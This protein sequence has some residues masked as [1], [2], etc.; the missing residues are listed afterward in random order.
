[1]YITDPAGEFSPWS[2]KRGITEKGPTWNV[3]SGCTMLNINSL[4]FILEDSCGYLRGS[5]LG[6][7]KCSIYSNFSTWRLCL[8]RAVDLQYDHRVNAL[9]IEHQ[10]E[11]MSDENP[12][13]KM[14]FSIL[15]TIPWPIS[16]SI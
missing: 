12:R 8:P 7:V 14:P 5:G 2:A 9:L 6:I 11:S 4:L 16:T 13:S 3:W 15:L 10:E 1:M